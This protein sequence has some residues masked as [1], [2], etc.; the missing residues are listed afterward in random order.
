MLFPIKDDY[1]EL[2]DQKLM[3]TGEPTVE[4]YKD[5]YDNEIGS[6]T[7]ANPH[8]ELRINSK[9]EVITKSRELPT[10]MIPAVRQW[11]MLDGVKYE[12]QIRLDFLKQEHFNEI[13]EVIAIADSG[14]IMPIDPI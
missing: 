10:D 9:T 5:Y 1:Q 14:G 2:V 12:A 6:F 13:D 3:I 8:T 7:L 4:V 11:A